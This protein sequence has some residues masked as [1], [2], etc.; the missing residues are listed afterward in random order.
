MVLGGASGGVLWQVDLL[1]GLDSPPPASV[2]T[3][4][5][6]SIFMFWGLVAPAGNHSVSPRTSLNQPEPA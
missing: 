6:V 3:L 4:K 5:S 2:L 1:P